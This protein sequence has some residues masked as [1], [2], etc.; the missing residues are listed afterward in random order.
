M[1]THRDTTA[2]YAGAL[3]VLSRRLLSAVPGETCP[4]CLEE[5][6]RVRCVTLVPCAHMMCSLCEA[7]VSDCPLCRTGVRKV[8]VVGNIDEART[9]RFRTFW[10]AT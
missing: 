4:V 8:V 7:M 10:G 2:A 1:D 9:H 5:L 3:R 6:T